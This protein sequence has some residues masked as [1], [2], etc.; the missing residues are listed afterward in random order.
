MKI[1]FE[2]IRKN[3]PEEDRKHPTIIFL[4]DLLE[5]QTEVILLLQEQIQVLRDEIARL[6]GQKPKPKIRPSK[7]TKDTKK[8]PPRKRPNDRQK[9]K[10]SSLEI[11]QEVR[12]AP[13]SIPDGSC[14]KGLKPFTV[15]G[16]RISSF[17]TCY[18]LVSAAT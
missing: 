1:K 18:L 10:T 3:I 7:L 9:D 16:L 13:E 8:K 17:N 15:R 4:L 6:K 11:H 14:F 12:I 2:Q 5:Q